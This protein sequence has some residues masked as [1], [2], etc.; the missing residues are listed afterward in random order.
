MNQ[1]T[2]FPA[3]GKAEIV[4]SVRIVLSLIFGIGLILAGIS[5]EV[6]ER[7]QPIPEDKRAF[8]G[9]WR[10]ASGFELTI[11]AEGRANLHQLSPGS[12]PD[13]DLLNI[14][15]APQDIRGMRVRFL[16][17][18]TLEVIDPLN[19]AKDYRIDRAPNEDGGRFTMVLNGVTLVRGN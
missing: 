7:A 4:P 6:F 12:Q 19:Y 17:P 16:G 8:I 3:T 15:V 18:D 9:T 1:H 10:S 11:L 14:K 13:S 5:C 2:E